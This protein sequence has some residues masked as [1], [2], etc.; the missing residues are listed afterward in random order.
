MLEQERRLIRA[1]ESKVG[2]MLRFDT[3][4]VNI[5]SNSSKELHPPLSERVEHLHSYG[6]DMGKKR[7]KLLEEKTKRLKE[8]EVKDCTF[9]PKV[10]PIEKINEMFPD[11]SNFMSNYLNTSAISN[12]P[13]VD[14]IYQWHNLVKEK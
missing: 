9:Q 1:K 8:E 14:R 4:F 7:A 13:H 11:Q 3:S 10:N 5:E 6:R 2:T 12:I